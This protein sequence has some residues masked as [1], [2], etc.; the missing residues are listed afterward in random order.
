M[1][2]YEKIYCEE[3]RDRVRSYGE[4]CNITDRQ[5][6]D[7]EKIGKLDSSQFPP[8]VANLLRDGKPLFDRVEDLLKQI[9]YHLNRG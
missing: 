7:F 1:N 9:N 5:I 2:I 6:R 3:L 4:L 8:I